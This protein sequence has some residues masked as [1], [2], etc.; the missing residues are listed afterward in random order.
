MTHSL[1]LGD[2]ISNRLQQ[3]HHFDIYGRGGYSVFQALNDVCLGALDNVLVSYNS[4]IILLGA[5]DIQCTR[6]DILVH[7]LIT[8]GQCLIAR[9]RQAKVYI[10]SIKKG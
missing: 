1:L 9:N 8:L 4:L 6:P 10:C 2:S 3:N 7:A 5:N